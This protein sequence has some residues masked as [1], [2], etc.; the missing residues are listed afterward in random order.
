[1]PRSTNAPARRDRKKKVLKRAKGFYGMQKSSFRVAAN[2]VR[3]AQ[4]FSYH[5]RK[6]KKRD[7]RTL[8]NVRIGAAAKKNGTKYSSLMHALKGAGVT[9]DRKVLADIAS[10]DPEGFAKIVEAA[11]S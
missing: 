4:A 10:S 8:W 9:L 2:K 11:R 7:F 3:R 5:G 1:M 6:L